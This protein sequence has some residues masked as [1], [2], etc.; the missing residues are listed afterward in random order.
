MKLAVGRSVS[1]DKTPASR[2]GCFLPETRP[3]DRKTAH[4]DAEPAAAEA[5]QLRRR[6]GGVDRERA[7]G[8]EEDGAERQDAE[9]LGR[10]WKTADR[11][12]ESC[13]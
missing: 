2:R 1:E 8:G 6:R 7:H 5:L 13:G 12:P 10:P 11:L 4:G 3:H 9:K